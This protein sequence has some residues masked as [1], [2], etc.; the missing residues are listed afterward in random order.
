MKESSIIPSKSN[1][2]KS[3]STILSELIVK[4]EF[5]SYR[6][7]DILNELLITPAM[8][9]YKTKIQIPLKALFFDTP[10]EVQ[11]LSNR[12]IKNLFKLW[13]I[14]KGYQRHFVKSLEEQKELLLALLRGEVDSQFIFGITKTSD[15]M[16]VID[17]QQRLTILKKFFNN[18]LPLPKNA[19]LKFIGHPEHRTIDC[20][21]MFYEDFKGHEI[22]DLLMDTI[23]NGVMCESVIHLG[24]KEQHIHVF[25]SLNTGNTKLTSM[26]VVTSEQNKVMEWVRNF[27]NFGLVYDEVDDNNWN[28]LNKYWTLTGI[29][30][31][32]YELSKLVLQ[33]VCHEV[34]GWNGNITTKQMIDFSYNNTISQSW[35]DIFEIFTKIHTDVVKEKKDYENS[36]L[37]GLQGWRVFLSFIRFIY[38][39]EDSYKVVVIDYQKFWLFAQDLMKNLR[40]TLG[41]NPSTGDWIF[42]EWKSHP[43]NNKKMILG[44]IKEFDKEF[45]KHKDHDSFLNETGISMRDGKRAISWTMGSLVWQLQ[46]GKCK[47]CNCRISVH[48]DKDHKVEWM[49]GGKGDTDIENIQL[50][51]NQCHKDKTKTIY[52]SQDDVDFEDT[53]EDLGE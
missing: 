21:D 23:L 2:G 6:G 43:K 48:D 37:W 50:L 35:K 13:N 45:I 36:D 29:S 51:C 53:S 26:E 17:S 31:L 16:D 33:C 49:N 47:K 42:D 30:G 40:T 46:D 4:Y 25:K 41:Q 1:D 24:T 14:P 27:N 18:T 15:T 52:K 44:L 39:Q 5:E 19:V 9:M 20:S 32:R 22:Y 28:K 8:P 3:I 34:Y 10:F 38:K 12:K 11:I 7:K